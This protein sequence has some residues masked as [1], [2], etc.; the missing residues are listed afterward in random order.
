MY[1]SSSTNEIVPEAHRVNDTAGLTCPPEIPL[2]SSKIR[3]SVAPM[4]KAFPVAKIEIKSKNVP[5][6]STSRTKTSI[7]DYRKE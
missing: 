7:L 2:M 1:A 6:N 4:T 5:K 3:V